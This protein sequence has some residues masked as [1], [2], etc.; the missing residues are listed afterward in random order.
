MRKTFAP[1]LA[2]IHFE[3]DQHTSGGAIIDPSAGTENTYFD[4]ATG[5]Y[6]SYYSEGEYGP[7]WYWW[8]DEDLDGGL[9]EGDIPVPQIPGIEIWEG[10]L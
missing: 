5:R 8:T 6:Y 9:Y 10:E 2:V 4:P 7:G 1:G 3:Y